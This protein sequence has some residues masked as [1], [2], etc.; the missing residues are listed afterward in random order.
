L[1]TEVE[2]TRIVLRRHTIRLWMRSVVRRHARANAR[3]TRLARR[4]AGRNACLL[5]ARVHGCQHP[6]RARSRAQQPRVTNAR[7]NGHRDAQAWRTD[8]AIDDR[9]RA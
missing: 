3:V 9:S 2:A 4:I 7:G 8:T 6:L 5:W 1:R